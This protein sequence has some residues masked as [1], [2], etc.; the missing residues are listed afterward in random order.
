M[1]NKWREPNC[2]ITDTQTDS[3]NQSSAKSDSNYVLGRSP[4]GCVGLSFTPTGIAPTTSRPYKLKKTK[5][6]RNVGSDNWQASLL[7]Y[8]PDLKFC[9]SSGLFYK[10]PRD[11]TATHINAHSVAHALPFVSRFLSLS[12]SLCLTALLEHACIIHL[13][14]SRMWGLVKN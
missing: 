13:A 12:P 7:L 1:E 2:D 9:G 11:R 6:E 4:R 3:E 14:T 8:G 5:K 10:G